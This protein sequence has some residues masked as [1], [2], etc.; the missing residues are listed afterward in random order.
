M[1]SAIPNY[2][3]EVFVMQFDAWVALGFLAQ[4]LF[5]LRL[6]GSLRRKLIFNITASAPVV[7]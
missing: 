6:H 5:S 1:L 3:H 2:L 7:V 4:A